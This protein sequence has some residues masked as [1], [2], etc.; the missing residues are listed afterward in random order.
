MNAE[1]P[2]ERVSAHT[3]PYDFERLE[4]CIEHLLTEHA[5]L[6]AEREA[7]MAELSDREHKV[8]SLEARLETERTLR[9][10]SLARV[11][12]ILE[13]LDGLES[14]VAGRAESGAP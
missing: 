2:G 4:Q 1:R 13:Q 10:A 14:S 12:R 6:N 9:A 11:D 7:L 5:R 8:N 3:N